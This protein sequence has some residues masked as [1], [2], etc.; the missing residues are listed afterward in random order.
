MGRAC[1]N[2][3][4]DADLLDRLARTL[5]LRVIRPSLPDDDAYLARE[6]PMPGEPRVLRLDMLL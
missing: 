2:L 3:A 5:L 1:D 6:V 4:R